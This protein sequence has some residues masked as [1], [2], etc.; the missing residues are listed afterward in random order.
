VKQRVPTAM[1]TMFT[2][3]VTGTVEVTVR[4][5]V[6][7]QVEMVLGTTLQKKGREG[8]QRQEQA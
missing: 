4:A 2:V 5:T 8:R 3:M 1:M 6:T 7:V